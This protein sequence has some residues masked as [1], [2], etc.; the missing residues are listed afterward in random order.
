M[1]IRYYPTPDRKC[2]AVKPWALKYVKQMAKEDSVPIVKVVTDAI[3]TVYQQR[4]QT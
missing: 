4:Q 3:T 2:V 1:P